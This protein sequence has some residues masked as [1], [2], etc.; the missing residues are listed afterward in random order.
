MAKRTKSTKISNKALVKEI[1]NWAD[2]QLAED[3]ANQ[4]ARIEKGID[5]D[6]P[7]LS[8]GP[9]QDDNLTDDFLSNF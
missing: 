3:I 6:F 4:A 7:D 5:L 1:L 8:D 9:T 2:E